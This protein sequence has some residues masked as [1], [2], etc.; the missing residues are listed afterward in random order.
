MKKIKQASIRVFIMA[1]L[2]ISAAALAQGSE[3]TTEVV[4]PQPQ[5]EAMVRFNTISE[6]VVQDLRAQLNHNIKHQ[7]NMALSHSVESIQ[8]SLR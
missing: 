7:V 4:Q 1:T 8:P 5:P 6:S 2:F 3:Q